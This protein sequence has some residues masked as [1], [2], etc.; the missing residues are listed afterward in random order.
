MSE[1]TKKSPRW[2]WA[3][4]QMGN[5]SLRV[6]KWCWVLLVLA[7]T[8][9]DSG[10]SKEVASS[11]GTELFP[12]TLPFHDESRYVVG[13]VVSDL[14]EMAY[15]AKSGQ[16]P[17]SLSTQVL[18]RKESRFGAPAYDVGIEWGDQT[19]SFTAKL[20]VI[21]AIWAPEVYAT[22]TT[23]LLRSLGVVGTA[24]KPSPTDEEMLIAL[25]HLTATN[26]EAANATLSQM[27]ESDFRNPILHERAAVLVGAFALRE[28]ALRF[29][30]VRLP[31]G[32]MT[33][34]LAFAR[35]LAPTAEPGVNGQLAWAMLET[36]MN[37]ET[38]AL[39]RI[40]SWSNPTLQ[41]WGRALEMRN[42][43]DFRL[44]ES[45]ANPTLVERLER[46]GAAS[47]SLN[48][49]LAF[50]RY[51]DA[52]LNLTPD[53]HRMISAS[54]FSVETGHRLMSVLMPEELREV[55][56]VSPQTPDGQLQPQEAIAFLNA[57][58]DRC[59]RRGPGGAVQVRVL[60]LGQWAGFLQ[61]QLCNAIDRQYE[62]L[63]RMWGVPDAAR[64]FKQQ[65]DQTFS[66]LRLYPFVGLSSLPDQAAQL[67]A[68][69]QALAKL[70]QIPQFVPPGVWA[71]QF[72]EVSYP[73]FQHNPL[74]GTAYDLVPRMQQAQFMN[75][76]DL[77]GLLNH[78]HALAPYDRD[79]SELLL[80]LKSRDRTNA[81]PAEVAEIYQPV[82]EY[83]P[84]ADAALAIASSNNPV[85]F[86]Q[87]M[88]KAADLAPGHFFA[89]GHYFS[90][91][92]EAKAANYFETAIKRDSDAIRVADDAGWL[93]QYY[94]RH[95]H[96]D[97][98]M[99]LADQAAEVYSSVGLRTKANLLEQLK[100]Y[101]E[102]RDYY[103]K[104]EERYQQAGPL[105]GFCVRYGSATGD[106]NKYAGF[107]QEKASV[108]FPR[109]VERVQLSKFRGP[110]AQG[111]M[112]AQNSELLRQAGLKK[113]DIVVALNGRRVYYTTQYTYLRAYLAESPMRLIVWQGEQY[114]EIVANPPNGLFGVSLEDYYSNR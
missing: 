73:W 3:T 12:S 13:M 105:V 2:S 59:F 92:D 112:F 23:G 68:W 72:E 40:R 33:A 18:E 4:N 58:P 22:T 56:V 76:T 15:Y 46:F 43:H 66:G 62:F 94:Y 47:Y 109:G 81:S 113:G 52:E 108:L 87:W 53:E 71:R 1:I 20:G 67:A 64:E 48:P 74:P 97:K 39:K 19:P 32:R 99:K 102:A 27:L 7:P 111:V 10:C 30:D 51:D 103:A 83:M 44:L 45:V 9:L 95:G 11:Q 79:L 104:I 63:T 90:S 65:C 38:P 100:R 28:H 17:P 88:R 93:V 106:T 77:A 110:P 14:A 82:L 85:E 5:V 86:E 16:R 35:G 98:A 70:R 41:A 8:L 89:L 61:R 57:E 96:T 78:L 36:L 29:H 107:L 25:Q 80:M 26:L 50:Q 37:N 75:H 60:G 34:H 114:I 69:E 6:T 49:E 101:D 42:T 24:P 21:R 91:R 55:S 31:L 54:T 84:T